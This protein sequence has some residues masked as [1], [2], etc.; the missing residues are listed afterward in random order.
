VELI[1]SR[2]GAVLGAGD[3]AAAELV[4]YGDGG[5]EVLRQGLAE[6]AGRWSTTLDTAALAPGR[7][8]MAFLC[9]YE[10]QTYRRTLSLEVAGVW[11][12]TC[13]AAPS[14]LLGETLTVSGSL[15]DGGAPVADRPV[16]V[17]ID[18]PDGLR[19]LTARTDASGAYVVQYLPTRRDAGA[20]TVTAIATNDLGIEYTAADSCSI[21]GL[22][23]RAEAARA[24]VTVG[25]DG[26]VGLVLAAFGEDAITIQSAAVTHGGAALAA[27]LQADPAGTVLT[28]GQTLQLTL[29]LAASEAAANVPVTVTVAYTTAGGRSGE[30]DTFVLVSAAREAGLTVRIAGIFA[31]DETGGLTAI[32]YAGGAPDLLVA[33][34]QHVLMDV[35]I[36]NQ[37]AQT[38]TN[39]SGSLNGLPWA[40]LVM[41]T[42]ASLA[43]GESLQGLIELNVPAA[44]LGVMSWPIELTAASDQRT[45]TLS[46]RTVALP[47]A[48]ATSTG[49]TLT[50]ARIRIA[51]RGTPVAGAAIRLR[52]A[53]PALPPGGTFYPAS[54]DWAAWVDGLTAVTD[55]AGEILINLPGGDWT[56]EL[57]LD[58]LIWPDLDGEFSVDAGTAG[59][60]A[61]VGIDL[62][63]DP[64]D[65]HFEYAESTEVQDV[66]AVQ[67]GVVLDDRNPIRFDQ[68]GREYLYLTDGSL[69][70]KYGNLDPATW[71]VWAKQLSVTNMTGAPLANVL[72]KVEGALAEYLRVDDVWP[73]RERALLD[74]WAPSQTI[75]LEWDFDLPG[76]ASLPAAHDGQDVI[77]EGVIRIMAGGYDRAYNLRVRVAASMDSHNGDP[78]DYVPYTDWAGRTNF[79]GLDALQAWSGLDGHT[80]SGT[81]TTVATAGFSQTIAVENETVELTC[82]LTN[83]MADTPLDLRDYGIR[84]LAGGADVTQYVDV[85]ALAG[86]TG[87]SIAPGATYTGRWTVTPSLPADLVEAAGGRVTLDVEIF[88]HA[89]AGA[90]TMPFTYARQLVVAAQPQL[91][92]S[93]AFEQTGP[94]EATL[95]TTVAN[96][97]A[98]D[99]R[100][101]SIRMPLGLSGLSD[102]W[103]I[104]GDLTQ[105]AGVIPAGGNAAFSWQLGFSRDIQA[106]ELL[107]ELQP[108]MPTLTGADGQTRRAPVTHVF[109]PAHT[110]DDLRDQLADF[111]KALVNKVENEFD[112]MIDLLNELI[113]TGEAMVD[114][115]HLNMVVDMVR[116]AC[117]L[118]FMLGNM[119]LKANEIAGGVASSL[120]GSP[121]ITGTSPFSQLVDK[122]FEKTISTAADRFK[123]FSEDMMTMQFND[124]SIDW[125]HLDDQQ[126]AEVLKSLI[127]ISPK[128]N[129]VTGVVDAPT[130]A[131]FLEDTLPGA[132][133]AADLGTKAAEWAGVAMEFGNKMTESLDIARRYITMEADMTRIMQK[134]VELAQGHGAVFNDWSGLRGSFDYQAR[135]SQAFFR[136]L[137]QYYRDHT[138]LPAT[139][140]EYDGILQRSQTQSARGLDD[141]LEQIDMLVRSTGGLLDQAWAKNSAVFP[142][143]LL[144][145]ELRIMTAV[146]NTLDPGAAGNTDYVEQIVATPDLGDIGDS[147]T[148]YWYAVGHEP[149]YY[150]PAMVSAE[151]GTAWQDM[152]DAYRYLGW[153]WENISLYSKWTADKSTLAL[154]EQFY[155]ATSFAVGAL[156]GTA[157][158]VASGAASAIGTI[159]TGA[160]DAYGQAI[161]TMYQTEQMTMNLILS[162]IESYMVNHTVEASS[163]WTFLL[164]YQN[165]IK[166]VLDQRP[167]DP[168]L[169]VR[170]DA[171]SADDA[172]MA[173]ADSPA[174]FAT[175][176]VT[177][178]NDGEVAWDTKPLVI[179]SAAGRELLR[180]TMSVMHV[181]PGQSLTQYF[182][183]ALPDSEDYSATG[184]DL[185]LRLDLFDPDT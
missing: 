16:V 84:F 101:V 143:D 12:V 67:L 61:Q 181:E 56:Y 126:S 145:N 77:V 27:A 96:G 25:D 75:M 44:V 123:K 71:D 57:D 32:P 149:N 46:L 43:P 92:I 37:S 185:E 35:S 18:T 65:F 152:H 146:L 136:E 88:G 113:D 40:V 175:G 91:Q 180:F 121:S 168:E 20:A 169:S 42:A 131:N 81:P 52:L 17:L 7:Y 83:R 22:D 177:L 68:P 184:F 38:L 13:E 133:T 2:T 162:A 142:T 26:Q 125:T 39:V 36:T 141:Y 69:P 112:R 8:A 49:V 41:D 115:G 1:D 11:Q 132:T 86:L 89:A 3:G 176:A 107:A 124:P 170:V 79:V 54:P 94:R 138:A 62:R 159:L 29:N 80:V 33:G 160:V 108:V 98:G 140:E 48:A 183:V 82:R 58:P 28:D 99:A 148:V 19:Y 135:N 111:Q 147:V 122:V 78:Y 70:L 119:L 150:A 182:P 55:A 128:L 157:G 134:I 153:Q 66:G 156:G 106:T 53:R 93:Y 9:I 6:T 85:K 45:G 174:G 30:A 137:A 10:G 171:F 90:G 97:G 117:Q 63:S 151:F 110:V 116:Y 15:T 5:G 172:V 21:G 109:K 60:E 50:P 73:M 104:S 114:A 14:V 118:T 158:Q 167:V 95:T 164:D 165:H 178:T 163:V 129:D 24:Q 34:G 173:D 23:L 179:V 72:V 59:G 105:T 166:Y 161:T 87:V 74:W 103:V 76:L 64:L 100:N 4:V 154:F 120:G 47:S 130:V 144:Y 31:L 51:D 155:Q 102:W 127:D 139:A